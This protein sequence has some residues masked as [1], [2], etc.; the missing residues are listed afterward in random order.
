[1]IILILVGFNFQIEVVDFKIDV[2][3]E[4]S[5]EKCCYKEM[6]SLDKINSEGKV[7]G[8]GIGESNL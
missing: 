2:N 6:D 7:N 4:R 5:D 1:M 3:G 8:L